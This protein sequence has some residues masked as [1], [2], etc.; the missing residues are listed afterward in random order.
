MARQYTSSRNVTSITYWRK[1]AE[2][3]LFYWIL[4]I[5]VG[6]GIV[7]MFGMGQAPGPV[8]R[9]QSAGGQTI[10]TVDGID[11][12]RAPY[13]KAMSGMRGSFASNPTQ[14]IG[15]EGYMLTRLIQNAALQAEAK[16]RGLAVTDADIDKAIADA[17]KGPDGKP[18]PEEQWQK[19]LEEQGTSEGELRDQL[20]QELLP[21][22]LQQSIERSQ[23]VTEQDLQNSYEQAHV[24]HILVSTSK[25]PD[26]QAKRKAEQVY[27]QVQAGKD[28]AALANQYSD[29]P[30]NRSTK[31]DPKLKKQVPMG[32]PKGGDLG[33][34][35]LNQ[36]PYVKE[37]S[38]TVKSLKPGQVSPPVKTQFGY[39]IIKLDGL[40]QN[41]PKDYAKNKAKLLEDFKKTQ[42]QKAFA[43]LTDQV[44]KKARTVWKD[45]SLKWRYDYAKA[46]PMFGVTSQTSPADQQAVQD[47]LKAYVAKNPDDGEAAMVLAQ[48]LYNQY[49]MVPPGPQKD[50]LR[51]EVI[52]DYET[53]LKHAGDENTQMT[54]AQ[55]YRDAKNDSKA[56]E[57]YETA[58]RL[59]RWDEGSQTKFTH[60]QLERAFKDLGHPELAA[61]E[62]KKIAELT[63]QEQEEARKRAEEAKKAPASTS[64][65]GGTIKVGAGGK[66]TSPT[67]LG[68]P[69]RASSI[70]AKGTPEKPAASAPSEGKQ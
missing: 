49:V 2:H 6:G 63:K 62:S 70:T 18:I 42:G 39:H 38:D 3:R 21:Q 4:A 22:V 61:V 33:W 34:A 20:R 23:K 7:V 45:P 69:G 44:M 31:W 19:R 13:E 36:L 29:D 59:L 57:H 10:A 58:Q 8:G 11:V 65:Q 9:S 5:V 48:T 15:M 53:A 40:R 26:E 17:K 50:K 43:D 47:E 60:M 68:V 37:F 66:A 55:L 35:P 27:K 16:R 24:S 41:L 64:L 46:N 28:F 12:P 32:A 52:A 1:W 67:V 14:A 25:L 54:L 30:G 56:L 51:N